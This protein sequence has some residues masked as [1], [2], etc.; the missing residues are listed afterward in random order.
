MGHQTQL[1]TDNKHTFASASTDIHPFDRGA[2][3]VL[4]WQGPIQRSHRCT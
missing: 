3:N 1:R 4:T 2:A